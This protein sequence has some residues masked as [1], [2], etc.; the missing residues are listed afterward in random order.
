MGASVSSNIAKVTSNIVSDISSNTMFKAAT[1]GTVNQIIQ[2]TDVNGNVNISNNTMEAKVTVNMKAVM[3][4]FNDTNVKDDLIQSLEQSAKSLIKDI[5]F[6]NVGL[7]QDII[8]NII[9]ETVN[10]TTNL[11]STCSSLAE[12][13]QSIIVSAVNGNINISKN[14]FNSTASLLSDCAMKALTSSSAI[15]SLQ[16]QI[17]QVSSAS[18]FGVSIWG[19]AAVLGIVLAGLVL[20]FVG[21]ELIPLIA[22]GKNPI[23]LG[24]IFFIVAAVFMGIYLFW[25]KRTIKSNV[26]HDLYRDSCQPVQI[27]DQKPVAS[28]DEASRLLLAETDGVAYDFVTQGVPSPIAIIYS[29]I[30]ANCSPP[31]DSTSIL[32]PRKVYY[33]NSA[34]IALLKG[35][36]E[37]DCYIKCNDATFSIIK[38]QGGT[39]SMNLA[40][41]SED[42]GFINTI[43]IGDNKYLISDNSFTGT[44]SGDGYGIKSTYSLLKLEFQ[45]RKNFT[46]DGPGYKLDKTQSADAS[47]IVYKQKKTWALYVSIACMVVGILVTVVLMLKKPNS[48][49]SK[50]KPNLLGQLKKGQEVLKK[51]PEVLK[52]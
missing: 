29:S 45:G 40:K 4:A 38:L 27:L 28:S 18:V 22:V 48:K 9:N 37:N 39:L 50:E 35:V 44:G 41:F 23:I 52:K 33:G 21:P 30:G 19:I 36:Q 42:V 24:V 49:S 6:G 11:S 8:E 51:D 34:N 43:N 2:I 12:T 25:T 13:N 31:P 16:N 46:L 7:A 47:G 5:N 15:S 3:E 20:I 1:S 17:K 26:W 14:T 32:T 10:I